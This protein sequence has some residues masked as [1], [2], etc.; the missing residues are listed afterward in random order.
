MDYLG[1]SCKV[2]SDAIWSPHNADTLPAGPPPTTSNIDT[3]NVLLSL[4]ECLTQQ[5]TQ[6]PGDLA[7]VVWEISQS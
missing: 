1:P 4:G 6:C 2:L 7:D 3:P 5:F